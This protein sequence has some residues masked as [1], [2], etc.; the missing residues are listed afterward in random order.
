[1]LKR[2]GNVLGLQMNTYK[3]SGQLEINSIIWRISCK[4]LFKEY[5]NESSGVHA[6]EH[7]Y[8]LNVS[9]SENYLHFEG[10]FK[11]EC[12]CGI[13]DLFFVVS[14]KVFR[15]TRLNNKNDTKWV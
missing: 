5:K 8:N 15:D 6:F 9:F 13:Y 11:S 1:M 2:K 12:I 14:R 10:Y 4:N 7:T 3:T